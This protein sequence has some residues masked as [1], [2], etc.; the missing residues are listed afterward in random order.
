MRAEKYV[1][2]FPGR[3][4]AITLAIA[5][6]GCAS[7]P[8]DVVGGRP[9]AT[10]EYLAGRLAARVNAIDDAARAFETASDIFPGEASIQ[11]G[12]F[13]YHVASG[14]IDGAAPYAERIAGSPSP[15]PR[16][17][18]VASLVLAAR[19]L[20][21]GRYA[22]ARTRL[23]A[24]AGTSFLD[25]LAFTIDVWIEDALHGPKAAIAKLDK[26]QEGVFAGFSPLHRGLLADKIGAAAD[27]R[28]GLES[29]VF[30]L[31]GP[32]G[33]EAFGAFLERSG[34]AAAARA[35]Y[36]VLAR[37]PGAGRRLA[38]AAE[39][40][41]A[42]AKPS[43]KYSFVKPEEGA[44]I[45]IYTFAAAMM[46]QVADEQ[47]RAHDS[48]FNLGEP[49]YDVPLAL[50]QI[51]LYLHPGLDDARRMVAD[52]LNIYGHHAEA[53]GLLRS[54]APA[55]PHFESAR[56]E[57]ASAL[58]AE[59]KPEEAA[60]LLKAA[61]RDDPNGREL[62]WT[63]AGVYADQKRHREAVAELTKLIDGLPAKPPADAW[64][65]FISRAASRM[66]LAHWPAA[67]TDLKRAVEIAPE[68][69][70]ALNYLGYSWA[71]RGVNLD[72]A[73]ELIEQAVAAEPRSGAYIDSLG[74]AH[75]QRGDYAEAVPHLE[76]AAAL[77]PGDP[78]ITDH[79]GDVYWRLGRTIEARYQWSRA[80]QLEPT[81][82]QRS[83]IEA[84]L[85]DG[86]P[87]LSKQ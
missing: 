6:S 23:A 52:V 43:T 79:L 1:I 28:A 27:A 11:K 19:E 65:Y 37:Q 36:Q 5:L 74:W 29:S 13:F 44:A 41:L 21:A 56:A 47:E 42:S 87:A 12:A 34:D 82:A 25:S 22:E 2:R 69:P 40:R 26:P 15:D 78:T 80:L 17:G 75:F 35:F 59:E 46:Q 84:K 39:L 76:K 50:A 66:E 9:T 62:R 24:P 7:V 16:A 33:R 4:V 67:E 38:G 61:L 85:K 58:I 77:E 64:R 18:G 49:Q 83:A 48:G 60:A 31:G 30:G 51:A 63:L 81:T 45:A 32:V 68:E 14:D 71:E 73:F 53:S 70:T 57:M 20:K 72:K 8:S 3:G 54:I 86:L 10:G 55:S